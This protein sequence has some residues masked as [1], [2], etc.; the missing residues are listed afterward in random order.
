MNQEGKILQ[1]QTLGEGLECLKTRL[2][3]INIH[4]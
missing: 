2:E 4:K 1:F 3:F